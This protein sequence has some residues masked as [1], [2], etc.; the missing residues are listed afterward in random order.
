MSS[1]LPVCSGIAA[2]AWF[3][4]R[5]SALQALVVTPDAPA[6]ARKLAAIVSAGF[7]SLHVVI[8]FDRT[9]TTYRHEGTLGATCHAILEHRRGEAVLAQCRALNNYY[10]PLE[11]SA[12]LSN[13]EKVPFMVEWYS[14]V[15][16]I[17]AG[18]GITAR[19]LQEDVA[20]A[21]FGLRRGVAE[22]LAA[23]ARHGFPVTIFSAGIGDVIEE[24]LR[25]RCYE[26]APTLPPNVRVVSNR[27]LWSP[28][29]LCTGFSANVLHPF[30]KNFTDAADFLPPD[31][32]ALVQGRGSVVIVGDGEG[33]AAMSIGLQGE[34]TVLKLGLLNDPSKPGLLDKYTKLF[35]IVCECA[36]GG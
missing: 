3:Y 36:C 16:A 35:D 6:T 9:I 30:N 17:L 25:Q 20:S 28:Q 32:L 23:A 8:D 7:D 18:C 21:H 34:P 1:L 31:Y 13:V 26:G 22:L 24:V 15:N 27:M 2:F 29:G 10:L 5:R 11:I 4:L 33:D 12:T 19:D 14:R